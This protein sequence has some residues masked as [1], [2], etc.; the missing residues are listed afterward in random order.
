MHPSRTAEWPLG[1][2]K[3]EANGDNREKVSER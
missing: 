1:D 3:Q 2:M